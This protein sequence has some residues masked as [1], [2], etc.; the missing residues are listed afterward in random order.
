MGSTRPKWP[1][2]QGRVM[3]ELDFDLEGER[4]GKVG[5]EWEDFWRIG[6]VGIWVRGGR[7]SGEGSFQEAY[8]RFWYRRARI[9]FSLAVWMEAKFLSRWGRRGPWIQARV[10]EE[11]D[12][13]RH[14]RTYTHQSRWRIATFQ[15]FS[16]W[17]KCTCQQLE[18]DQDLSRRRNL[19]QSPWSEQISTNFWI[20]HDKIL[21]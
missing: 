17:S 7:Q 10:P 14:I 5:A 18:F 9:A 6:F 19:I 2:I 12:E 16:Y 15:N 21:T 20:P 11:F 4:G 1:G 13:E 8:G 3:E